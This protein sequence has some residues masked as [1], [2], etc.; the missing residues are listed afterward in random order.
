MQFKPNMDMCRK[1]HRRST[2]GMKL[3]GDTPSPSLSLEST[4]E[5]SMVTLSTALPLLQAASTHTIFQSTV[6]TLAVDS[7][8]DLEKYCTFERRA[9]RTIAGCFRG[10]VIPREPTGNRRC[11][12]QTLGRFW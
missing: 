4:Q 11:R 10:R 8:Q 12:V 3:H 5:V 6:D 7:V 9:V 2:T 1:S